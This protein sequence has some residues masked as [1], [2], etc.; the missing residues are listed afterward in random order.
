LSV[1]TRVDQ[2]LI[3][4]KEV[5]PIISQPKKSSI[6]F[7][8]IT[9]T[10]MLKTNAFNKSNNFST[11]GSYRKYENAKKV[12]KT[13]IEVVKNI[14]LYEVKSK[15][16]SSLTSRRPVSLNHLE[17]VTLAEPFFNKKNGKP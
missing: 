15:K 4:K 1:P 10:I 12:T 5:K 17:T 9:R 2:K 6:K 7:P 13:A 8:E 16:K 14:K 11:L 3:N